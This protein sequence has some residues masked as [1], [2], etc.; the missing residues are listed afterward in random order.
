MPRSLRQ[1]DIKFLFSQVSLTL[2]RIVVGKMVS[3]FFFN[4]IS[5]IDWSYLA[6]SLVEIEYT[7]RKL[8]L[9]SFFA[10]WSIWKS[11]NFEEQCAKF[12]ETYIAIKVVPKGFELTDLKL[13]EISNSSHDYQTFTNRSACHSLVLAGINKNI[14]MAYNL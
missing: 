5:K 4:V 6:L 14:F 8:K 1:Y 2:A 9:V 12:T 10:T 11:P 13:W 3:L 7:S